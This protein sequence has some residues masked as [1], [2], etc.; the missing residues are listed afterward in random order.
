VGIDCE[1]C[2]TRGVELPCAMCGWQ[3]EPV[4]KP[5]VYGRRKLPLVLL[6]VVLIVAGAIASW[7]L[8]LLGVAL[9]GAG[10]WVLARSRGH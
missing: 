1:K 10:F 2:G 7:R 8:R 4:A 5:V 6:S 9:A 3:G